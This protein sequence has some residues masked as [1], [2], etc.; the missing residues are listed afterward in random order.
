MR[1]GKL[2]KNYLMTPYIWL[3]TVLRFALLCSPKRVFLESLL[4]I[5]WCVPEAIVDTQVSP[6]MPADTPSLRNACGD[7]EFSPKRFVDLGFLGFGGH[8]CL[9]VPVSIWAL[10]HGF[11]LGCE[12]L[13]SVLQ[14]YLTP[15]VWFVARSGVARCPPSS[16]FVSTLLFLFSSL[17]LIC[18]PQIVL[19]PTSFSPCL[20]SPPELPTPEQA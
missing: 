4:F 10:C 12:A 1:G 15:N 17:L 16:H 6:K 18:F 5:A 13:L 11:K 19:T 7:L 8:P 2:F 20:V 3:L 14:N 9:P